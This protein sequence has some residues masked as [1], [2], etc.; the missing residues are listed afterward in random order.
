MKR[1]PSKHMRHFSGQDFFFRPPAL[2]WDPSDLIGPPELLVTPDPNGIPGIH[3][4]P[5]IAS[6]PWIT[7]ICYISTKV[8]NIISRVDSIVN[9]LDGL[10][11]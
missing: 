5:R 2:L 3:W 10:L 4:T 8:V 11:E 7:K 9:I 6:L 1:E